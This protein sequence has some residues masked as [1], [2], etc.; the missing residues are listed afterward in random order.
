MI[1]LAG[2]PLFV[3]AQLQMR[4]RLRVVVETAANA[5]KGIATLLLL[6]L[7]AQMQPD[8][9]LSL[10][11]AQV[12]INAHVPASTPALFLCAAFLCCRHSLLGVPHRMQP[13]P[14]SLLRSPSMLIAC[15]LSF[16]AA[17]YST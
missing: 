1:E 17:V 7:P 16:S 2:E 13:C 9:A 11:F 3:L 4:M 14:S 5:A 15:K 8:P 12:C 10:S 6:S